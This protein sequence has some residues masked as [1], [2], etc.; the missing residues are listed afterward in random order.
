MLECQVV[1]F[2]SAMEGKCFDC[3]FCGESR[4]VSGALCVF[5]PEPVLDEDLWIAVVALFQ[6]ERHVAMRL[7]VFA[8]RQ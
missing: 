1:E 8:C 5:G 2:G 6:R 4:V 3:C 7:A